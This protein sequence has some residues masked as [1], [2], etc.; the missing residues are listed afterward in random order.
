LGGVEKTGEGASMTIVI[1]DN[2]YRWATVGECIQDIEQDATVFKKTGWRLA[3]KV[4]SAI[5][6]FGRNKETVSALYNALEEHTGLSRQTL[7]NMVSS[8]RKFPPDE[9]SD[10]LTMGHHMAML[11]IVDK[12]QL[13][14][15]MNRAESQNLSVRAVRAL[16]H[17]PVAVRQ[18][19]N[20]D[21]VADDEEPPFANREYY[22]EQG[23]RC[24]HCGGWVTL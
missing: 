14:Y 1:Q 4:L 15:V 2:T 10:M 3:D 6:Q 13:E 17:A 19:A 12:E 20:G 21:Y 22:E 9:R 23:V 18:T 7:Q 16:V 5:E 8:A 24:P 11:G